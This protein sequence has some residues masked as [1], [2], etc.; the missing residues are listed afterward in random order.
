VSTKPGTIVRPLTSRIVAPCGTVTLPRGPT[1]VIR[2]FT[3]TT[4]AFSMISSPRIV[5][6]RPPRSTI[7]PC[8]VSRVSST[9]T[10]RSVGS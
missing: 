8:G 5:I 6:T 3:T 2:L 4:S 1:A 7:A 9:L 10:R